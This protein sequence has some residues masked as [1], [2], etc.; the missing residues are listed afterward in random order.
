MPVIG[1]LSEGPTDATV[2]EAFI[3][4][5]LPGA[6]CLRLHPEVDESGMMQASAGGTGYGWRGVQ[7]YCEMIRDDLDAFLTSVR[8]QPLDALIVHVDASMAD[9]VGAERPCPQSVD[10]AMALSAVIRQDWLNLTMP[11]TDVVVVTPSKEIEAWVVAAL[12]LPR[13][14]IVHIECDWDVAMELVRAKILKKKDGVPKKSQV[15]YRDMA[16]GITKGVP[17]ILRECPTAVLFDADLS[18]I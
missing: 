4:A 15:A 13:A 11:R 10:T 8:D 16:P 5:R 14:S 2:I 17:A 12:A 6:V 3:E 18:R 9:K 1:I 7:S